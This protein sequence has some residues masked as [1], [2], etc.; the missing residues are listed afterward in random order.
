[1]RRSTSIKILQKRHAWA[2]WL[3]FWIASRRPQ[4]KKEKGKTYET[5]QNTKGLQKT[6]NTKST[7]TNKYPQI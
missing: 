4:G 3:H 2:G 5:M 1:M 6:T 7:G